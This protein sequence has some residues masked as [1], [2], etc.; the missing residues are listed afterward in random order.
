MGVLLSFRSGLA[1]VSISED[2]VESRNKR[3]GVQAVIAA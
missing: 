3:R 2:A 1:I